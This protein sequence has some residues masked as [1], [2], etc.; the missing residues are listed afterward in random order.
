MG[1]EAKDE[2]KEDS[3]DDTKEQKKSSSKTFGKSKGFGFVCFSNPD[4]ASKAVSEMNQKM[5]NQK[6][7][8]VALAQRKDVRKNQL[9]ASIQ[10]RNTL[11]QQQQA[12]AAG[13]PQ[14]QQLP[15]NFGMPGQMPFMQNPALVNGMYNNPQAL[16]QMQAQMG[17]GAGGRG[18]MQ[19]MQGMPPNMQAMGGVRGGPNFPQGGGRG[20][21]Q[22]MPGGQGAGRMPPQGRGQMMPNREEVAAP[23][24]LSNLASLPPSQ[25]KQMLGEAIYPKI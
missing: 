24:T 3:K 5:V 10:A 1:D 9:E 8:Y 14:G 25:Q 19:G 23:S 15:P 11:R 2:S 20:G 22:N 13:M 7:L 18:Q 17:R 4:E 21:M 6:P 16:A 12:A